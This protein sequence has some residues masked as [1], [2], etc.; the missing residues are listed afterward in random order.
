ML[1]YKTVHIKISP[2]VL[3]LK[4][5]NTRTGTT[6]PAIM[7]RTTCKANMEEKLHYSSSKYLGQVFSTRG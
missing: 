7:L 3:E 4:H 5:V 6:G 1:Q 2:V